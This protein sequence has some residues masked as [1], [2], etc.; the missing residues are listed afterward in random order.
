[1]AF[2]LEIFVSEDDI[3]YGIAYRLIAPGYQSFSHIGIYERDLSSF[4]EV[5]LIG[6]KALAMTAYDILRDK[7]LQDDAYC[8]YEDVVS[9][10]YP[11]KRRRKAD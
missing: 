1:M 9:D 10:A 2:D 5:C 4:D 3:D 8:Y 11:Q 7:K 6:A